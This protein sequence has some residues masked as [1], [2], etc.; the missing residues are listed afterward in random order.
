MNELFFLAIGESAIVNNV[1]FVRVQ[2][3]WIANQT[4][5][6]NTTS[7]FVP[8]VSMLQCENTIEVENEIVEN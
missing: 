6:H 1:E 3:G 8:Y 2:S 4:F 5:A 7:T